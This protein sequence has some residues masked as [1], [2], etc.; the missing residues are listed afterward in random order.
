MLDLFANSRG[1]ELHTITM[2]NVGEAKGQ[3]S[4]ACT[5]LHFESC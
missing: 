4:N 1:S 2:D 5:E 3:K